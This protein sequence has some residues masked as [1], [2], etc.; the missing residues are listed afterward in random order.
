[1][2]EVAE[3]GAEVAMWDIKEPG[4]GKTRER[5]GKIIAANGYY[6]R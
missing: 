4:D 1:M 3:I 6:Q 2:S 5:K